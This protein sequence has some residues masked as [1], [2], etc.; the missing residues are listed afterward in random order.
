M[1]QRSAIV[2]NIFDESISFE[3]KA[4]QVLQYQFETNNVYQEWCRLMH[5]DIS[6]IQ[7]SAAIP[8][9]PISFFKTHQVTS[10]AFE[11]QYIFES[12]G[13]TTTIN[14]RHYVKDADLYRKSFMHCF[15]MF[16]GDIKEW[17]IIGL[18]PAYLERKN[19]SL[20]VMVDALIKESN[21]AQ[22]GFYLYEFEQ[23]KSLLTSLE[24]RQQKTLLIGV[25]FALL[26]FAEQFALPLQH[27]VI[28][29]T[30]GMKGRRKE[31]TRQEVHV[32]LMKSFGVNAVHSEYGMTELLSQAYSKS[33]G[34]FYCPP[35]MKVLARDEEDPLIVK[36]PGRGVLNI[37]DLANIDSCSF[38]ATDDAGIVYEDGSFEVL[39]RI[40]NS[41]IRG[42]SLLVVP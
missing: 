1:M 9:L 34:R 23:V 39:G 35:W 32:K 21:H 2:N 41:D 20:V 26:D 8:F 28:M 22:S 37:I 13:T 14:S 27:T 12:S 16:Y 6:N 17:C 38:I 29:E 42:C 7:S 4:R 18:L 40:D 33:N 31:L 19:S 30:G 15:E 5:A 3:Q 25:T 24:Q 10:T 36:E 11:P